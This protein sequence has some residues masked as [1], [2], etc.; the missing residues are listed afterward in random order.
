[1]SNETLPNR[2]KIRF[3]A[4]AVT[5]ALRNKP[6]PCVTANFHH[7]EH[8]RNYQTQ[9]ITATR[10]GGAKTLTAQTFLVRNC[11]LPSHCHD[12]V[13]A[14]SHNLLP[15]LPHTFRCGSWQSV[16]RVWTERHTESGENPRQAEDRREAETTRLGGA[17]HNRIAA[18]YDGGGGR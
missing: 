18:R 12:T 5:K 7:S 3:T 1:M 16:T 17:A 6:F 11:Q 4:M 13:M 2:P 14:V 15:L 8:R 9:P 10:R